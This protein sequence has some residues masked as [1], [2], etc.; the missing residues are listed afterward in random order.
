MIFTCCNDNRRAALLGNAAL[1]GIDYLEVV[2]GPTCPAGID[3]QRTLLVTLLNIAP[4]NVL[5]PNNILITGGES[6]T[7]IQVK[8]VQPVQAN[9][10]NTPD[11]P[12][13]VAADL[14]KF[15]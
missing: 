8:W 10:T 12:A 2:D 1:Y 13:D 5:K 15:A 6:I 3:R 14:A 7:S 4:F 9:T 11:L